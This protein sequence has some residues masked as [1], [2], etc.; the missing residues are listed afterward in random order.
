MFPVRLEIEKDIGKSIKIIKE[1]L[2]K[3]PNKGIGYGS[4]CGYTTKALPRIS[5]N[6]LGQFNNAEELTDT[7][8][9]SE[10]SSGA[11]IHPANHDTNI[12]D[13]NGLVLEGRLQFSI[14]SKLDE[15]ITK[16][17]AKLFKQKLEEVISHTVNQKRSYLTAS[18]IDN[19]ISQAHLDRLQEVREIANIYKANSL[20]QGFI[21]H[22][23]HQGGC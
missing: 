6:Y 18:D 8:S 2:R 3:I 22:A 15:H 10:E 23:L 7:W 1:S 19:I 12:L 5:F 16:K 20:Q 17:A 4:L 13:I 11:P 9:I 21:Y 14:S